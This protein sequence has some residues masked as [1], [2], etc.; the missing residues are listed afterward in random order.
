[1]NRLRV[2]AIVRDY[3]LHDRAQAPEDSQQAHGG[4]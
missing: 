2:A 1:L 3:G 4:L